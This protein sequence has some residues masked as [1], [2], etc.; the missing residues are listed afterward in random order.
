MHNRHFFWIKKL[1]VYFKRFIY[2]GKY[3]IYG[4]TSVGLVEMY[5]FYKSKIGYAKISYL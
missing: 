1:N 2:H 4:I 3:L 5:F